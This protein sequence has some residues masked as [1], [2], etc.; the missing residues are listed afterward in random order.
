MAHP[1]LYWP[2]LLF[3]QVCILAAVAGLFWARH[4]PASLT[5]AALLA[6]LCLPPSRGAAGLAALALSFALGAAF[7]L[8]HRVPDGPGPVPAWVAAAVTPGGSGASHDEPPDASFAGVRLR[9][10]V[11]E[12]DRLPGGRLRLTL[13][14]V[15][16]VADDGLPAPDLPPLP[17]GLILAWRDPPP[18]IDRV[19]P[20]QEITATLRL[21]E[22]RSFANPGVWETESYWR[23]RGVFYRA[24]VR[25]TNAPKGAAPAKA[26]AENGRRAGPPPGYVIG[27]APSPLWSAREKLRA[28]VLAALSRQEEAA[29]APGAARTG[30]AAANREGKA[31]SPSGPHPAVSQA[32]AVIP[33]LLFGDRSQCAPATLDLVARAT[34]AHSL[35]LSGMH[36]GFAAAAGYG[37]ATLLGFLFPRLFL[38]LPRQKA[39]LLLAAPVCAIYLWLGA[40]PPSLV[41]AALMLLFWAWLLWRNRPKVLVDGLI[42]ALAAILLADPASLYDLRLQLSVVSIAGIALALPLLDRLDALG[43]PPPPSGGHADS[44]PGRGSFLRRAPFAVLALLGLSLATQAAVLPLVIDAFGGAGL[45]LPLN[46][47]WLPVLGLA[48]MPLSFAGLFC[49]ALSCLGADAFL[50]L[51]KG[52]FF[53]AEQ[54]CAALIGLLRWLDGANVLAAPAALRP[55]WPAWAGFWLLLL[56][57][58]PLCTRRFFTRRTACLAVLGMALLAGPSLGRGLDVL[59]PAVRLQLADVGQGQAALISWQGIGG[60]SGRALVDGGGFSGDSFDVGRRIVA[61]MLTAEHAPDLTW[62]VNTHADTDHLQGLLY[63]LAA[64]RVG[65]FAGSAAEH[66]ESAVPA[67]TAERILRAR[68]MT[69]ARWR[70]G[71]VIP[72]A[73][74]LIL[75]VLHPPPGPSGPSS[76]NNNSLALRLVWNGAGLALIGGDLEK[77]GLRRLLDHARQGRS[78]RAEV[79]VLPHHGSGGSLSPDLYAAVDPALALASCGHANQWNFPSPA[80]RRALAARGIPLETTAARGQISLTWRPGAKTD[81]AFAR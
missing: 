38:R 66:P 70:A 77:P 45:W 16:R 64:F 54:P 71:D 63:P 47:V 18:D 3:R 23:G 29:P 78:L 24:S 41:R 81:I 49:A 22:I 58:P 26:A 2:P 37:A 39:G 7:G 56:L 80:V 44:V 28:S 76:A 52:L 25:G 9:G 35:A 4:P 15:R 67:G 32:A 6:A 69:P 57:L 13:G 48:V 21:R 74:G 34:L 72:L 68:G 75:E 5:A 36:L 65:G 50:P 1:S 53:L 27:G 59:R 11:R 30:G 55:A 40:S 19:G 14:S 33:A 20:G 42:W 73:P 60:K 61:P 31:P 43:R 62:I 10:T 17:G 12:S 46:L 79:L 8:A 51:A